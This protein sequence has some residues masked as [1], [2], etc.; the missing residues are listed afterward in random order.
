MKKKILA[1]ALAA[2]VLILPL[3]AALAEE[4]TVELESN[5]TTGY[6][7]T[8]AVD[9]LGVEVTEG[10]MTTPETGDNLAGAPGMQS[11][12]VTGTAAGE[13]ILT[14][15]YARSWEKSD[16]DQTVTM[17][18]TVNDD[19]AVTLEP[20][21]DT[22]AMTLEGLGTPELT[23][24]LEA[25]ATTGYSWVL[26]AEGEAVTVTEEEYK[27]DEAADDAVGVGGVQPYLVKAVKPGDAKLIFTYAQAWEPE[28]IANQLMLFLTVDADGNIQLQEVK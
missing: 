17:K 14:F 15:T 2:A 21:S 8:V 3:S 20:I 13:A 1:I 12:T 10:E 28:A 5:P 7:W 6:Q 9:G 11:F 26:A 25:N 19:L 22:R 24:L 16:D 18:A 23:I 4:T 27:A